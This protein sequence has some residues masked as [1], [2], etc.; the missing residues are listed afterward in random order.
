[1]KQHLLSLLLVT[2]CG[3]LLG[4]SYGTTAGLRFANSDHARMIGLTLQHRV[5]NKITLEGILQSDFNNNTTF[6]TLIERHHAFLTKRFNL[7]AG[8]GL[9]IGTE[10][11]REDDELT[12]QVITT[13]G[14]NTIGTDIIFG[15]EATL[16]SYN[17]S[18]DYKPNF[19]L[20]GRQPWYQGQV[21]ISVRTVLISGRQ[22]NKN[23]RQRARAKKKKE[24]NNDPWLK[25][26]YEETFKK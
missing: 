7:Y 17:I 22:Q 9:S 26:W 12:N 6:H 20:S 15:F 4:Q 2:L 13:F 25:D 23:K 5:A 16:L 10:E 21:G 1:M 8:A 3:T 11:S 19:N 14:N 18:L 24:R